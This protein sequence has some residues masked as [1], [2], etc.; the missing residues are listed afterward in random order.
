MRFVWSMGRPGLAIILTAVLCR[1][2]IVATTAADGEPITSH[3]GSESPQGSANHSADRPSRPPIAEIR[4]IAIFV[5]DS[6][7][8]A[9]VR[10]AVETER[11]MRAVHRR[12]SLFG[13][14]PGPAVPSPAKSPDINSATRARTSKSS[15][16]Q[17]QA[18]NGVPTAFTTV[19]LRAIAQA[20][21]IDAVSDRLS[22]RLNLQVAPAA[23]TAS[24]VNAL[25]LQATSV[26]DPAQIAALCLRLDCDAV[27]IPRAGRVRA[28]EADSRDFSLWATF[29]L[30][31]P[32]MARPGGTVRA[33]G[34]REEFEFPAA[35]ASTSERAPFQRR[36]M[37]EIPQLALEA[38][39]ECA[40]VGART[41]ATGIVAP[42]M[43][44][45]DRA[46]IA[47]VSA[48][49]QADALL[50]HAGGRTVVPAALTNLPRDVSSLFHPDLLPLLPDAI[51][52][53]REVAGILADEK[54]QAGRLWG[55]D[56][57]LDRRRS[58][59]LGKRAGVEYVLLA[60]ISDLELALNESP[61][62]EAKSRA[63][64]GAVSERD[65]PDSANMESATAEATGALVRVSDGVVLWQERTKA[66]MTGSMHASG[67]E[68]SRRHIARDAEKF[69]LAQ[70][71]RRFRQYRMRFE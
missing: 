61:S 17:S 9:A 65:R 30:F 44:E 63:A 40:A 19:Q 2:L 34:A 35:G 29:R 15:R 39:R 13:P 10:R 38:A 27:L 41:L 37:K 69:A 11:A 53:S 57:M 20:F 46:A 6:Y 67:S 24:T 59:E 43:R 14:P 71:D 56:E 28:R 48:P 58:V 70:L 36:Y 23:D 47:P 12:R 21:L 54:L 16:G 7:D 31:R 26:L 52:T 22:S 60:R 62:E 8:D 3:R 51:V 45:Q 4:R 64:F 18:V 25:R 68:D 66:M 49:S 50:F 5:T 33:P 1:T 32:R 42:L 55:K